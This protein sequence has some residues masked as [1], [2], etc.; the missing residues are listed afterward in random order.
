VLES[1]ID[2]HRVSVDE[3]YE[4]VLLRFLAAKTKSRG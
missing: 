3:N 4:E 2:Y 1:A